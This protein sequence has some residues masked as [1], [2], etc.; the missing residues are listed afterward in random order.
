MTEP[1]L[2]EC[3]D[4]HVRFQL[5]H[6]KIHALQGISLKGYAGK[7][8][9][10]VGESGCG[11]STFARTLMGLVSHQEGEIIFEGKPL[12]KTDR[13]SMQMVFQDPDAS[14][15]P[16]MTVF[17]HLKEALTA[18]YK[19]TSK[20]LEKK[21]EA[22]LKMV[23]IPIEFQDKYPYSSLV[24]KTA[25]SIARAL[26]IEPKLIICDE[27]L[28]SLDVSIS[29]QMIQLL[30]TL[31]EEQQL[32]YLFITHDLASLS[33]LAH[34][35]AVLYLGSLVELA[36]SDALFTEPLH[37]YS[38]ALLSSVLLPDPEKEKNR[39][40]IVVSGELPSVTNP[41]VGCVFSSR[42]PFATDRCKTERPQIKELHPNH[43]VACH[44]Y[45]KVDS[46]VKLPN[47]Q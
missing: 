34:S 2:F 32:A 16:R 20:E 7:T 28:A 4:I 35:V 33:T 19:L 42:C 11:K 29:A 22:L 41:P 23:Q 36:P 31:Q 46:E 39:S 10:V 12:K 40:K 5:R 18:R 13:Q 3:K 38:K 17:N 14:L 47:L 44:F 15:N 21:V 25:I 45:E 6:S 43:F 26:S 37:P 8:L 27:P 1:C 24:A 9:G 30:K